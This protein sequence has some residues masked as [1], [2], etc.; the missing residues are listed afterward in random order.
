MLG[1]RIG[2]LEGTRTRA[3]AFRKIQEVGQCVNNLQEKE[4]LTGGEELVLL[5]L[6]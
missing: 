4:M 1:K 6:G 2:L 5:V 3:H